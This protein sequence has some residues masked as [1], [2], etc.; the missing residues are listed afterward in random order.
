MKKKARVKLRFGFASE[1]DGS[2]TECFLCGQ[3]FPTRGVRVALHAKEGDKV[4][5]DDA[6]PMCADCIVSGPRLVA[7][8][9]KMNATRNRVKASMTEDP[10]D[11]ELY[12]LS[13]DILETIASVLEQMQDFSKVDSY[14]MAAK[15][16]EAYIN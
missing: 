14:R 9:A 1:S 7:A 13:A 6:T 10:D 5:A 11:Q 3:S 8:R 15:I 2:R 16:A 4:L 12:L